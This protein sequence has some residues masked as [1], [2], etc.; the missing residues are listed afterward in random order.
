M[1]LFFEISLLFDLVMFIFFPLV[2]LMFMFLYSGW[3]CSLIL[4]MMLLLGLFLDL[5]T[6]KK[7]FLCS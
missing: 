3:V 6:L 2:G 7:K 5:R 1:F 4:G